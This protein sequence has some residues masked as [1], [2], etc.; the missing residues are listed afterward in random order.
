MTATC[1]CSSIEARTI[2]LDEMPASQIQHFVQR[3]KS[4][5]LEADIMDGKIEELFNDQS[6][7][8]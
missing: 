8:P 7:D 3:S 5:W 6:A 2:L 4:I 1:F